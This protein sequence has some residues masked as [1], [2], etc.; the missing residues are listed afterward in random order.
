MAWGMLRQRLAADG[1]ADEVSVSS[2]GVYGVVAYSVEQRTR[3]LGVRLALGA[4]PSEVF[5]LVLS[6]GL[7]LAVL[8][9]AAGVGAAVAVTRAMQSLLYDTAATDPGTYVAMVV[10]ALLVATLACLVPALRATRVDP[11]TALRAE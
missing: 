4:R 10:V 1:L 11:L 2:A 7:T 8:G 9:V 5:R 6:E 3:E